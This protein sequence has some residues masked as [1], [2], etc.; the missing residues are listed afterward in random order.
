MKGDCLGQAGKQ[1]ASTDFYRRAVDTAAALPQLPPELVPEVNRARQ[2]IDEAHQRYAQRLDDVLASQKQVLDSGLDRFAL[3]IDLLLKRKQRYLQQPTG[4]FFPSLPDTQFHDPTDFGWSAAVEAATRRIHQEYLSALAAGAELK[5][6]IATSPDHPPHLT[7]LANSLDWSAYHLHETGRRVD[8]HVAQCPE[9]MAA[10]SAVPLPFLPGVGPS[11]FFSVLRPGA[12][13]QSHHGMMNTRLVCHLPLIIPPDCAIRVG[14]ETRSW[15]EGKLLIF[16]DAIEHE[17]WNRS[18]Q[19]R[20]VLIFEIWRPELSEQEQR[21]VTAL[22][23]AVNA[24]S[25]PA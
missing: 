24:Q 5:P 8:E 20:V 1:R 21:A 13:I 11:V 2:A 9:T 12:H 7:R 10:L 18:D 14:N 6:F 17:A 3:S 22:Y 25:G 4:Y 19:P 16:N 15:E 23:E